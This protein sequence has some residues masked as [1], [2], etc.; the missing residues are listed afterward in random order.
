MTRPS[1]YYEVGYCKPHWLLTS[2]STRRRVEQLR[3]RLEAETDPKVR[4]MVE[5]QLAVLAKPR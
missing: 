3:E 1:A 5:A 2:T 4:Q